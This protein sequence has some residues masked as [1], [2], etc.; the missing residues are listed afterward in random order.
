MILIP[1]YLDRALVLTTLFIGSSLEL[2]H[3]PEPVPLLFVHGPGDSAEGVEQG[4]L[5]LGLAHED[6]HVDLRKE[7]SRLLIGWHREMNKYRSRVDSCIKYDS[8]FY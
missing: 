6:A 2:I 5:Q 1:E 7:E 4:G 3:A 8:I